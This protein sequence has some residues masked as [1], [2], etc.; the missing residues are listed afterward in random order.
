[1]VWKP[2]WY[3]NTPAYLLG[4]YKGLDDIIVIIENKWI[5]KYVLPKQISPRYESVS[6]KL[7]EVRK[8]E[9]PQF[10]YELPSYD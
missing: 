2:I 6:E 5:R 10:K 7:L 3:K 9:F 1:M 4:K 8:S